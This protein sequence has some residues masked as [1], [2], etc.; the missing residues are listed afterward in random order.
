MSGFNTAAWVYSAL[1]LPAWCAKEGSQ[2]A[3]GG[4]YP[5]LLQ[6]PQHLDIS[7]YYET[8]ILLLF[9]YSEANT[10]DIITVEKTVFIHSSQE[11]GASCP[12]QGHIGKH[13]GWWE[14]GE[15]REMC[16]RVLWF[17]REGTTSEAG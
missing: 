2:L 9:R 17:L 15:E 6:T 8:Q 1:S 10:P 7:D 4:G 11:E 3:K 5:P 16:V 12:M 14:A 13:Q